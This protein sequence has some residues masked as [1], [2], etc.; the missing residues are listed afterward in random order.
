MISGLLPKPSDKD[1]CKASVDRRMDG[2][3]RASPGCAHNFLFEELLVIGAGAY[4]PT[5]H[6][7]SDDV[8]RASATTSLPGIKW[9]TRPLQP[10]SRDCHWGCGL[11]V[12]PFCVYLRL[13]R[14]KAFL[15]NTTVLAFGT[16]TDDSVRFYDCI[17]EGPIFFVYR[18]LML[19]V[20]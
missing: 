1:T 12:Q 18:L 14:D 17:I 10:P 8:T 15:K 19:S 3:Q 2:R 20:S 7:V 13:S 16:Q 5:T 4:S 11:I 6:F 9:V